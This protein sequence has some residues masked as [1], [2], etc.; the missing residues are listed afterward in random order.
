MISEMMGG[1]GIAEAELLVARRGGR[2]KRVIA[3]RV[4][5]QTS[6]SLRWLT[7]RLKMGSEGHLSRL[8][9]SLSDLVNHPGRR[10]FEKATQR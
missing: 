8:A 6:V 10:G 3:Q 5:Q 7:G 2:R 4:R 1:L 9:S